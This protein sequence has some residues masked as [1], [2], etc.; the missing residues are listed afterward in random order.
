MVLEGKKAAIKDVLEGYRACGN[1]LLEVTVY[2][3]KKGSLKI[4]LW[5][6]RLVDTK[7]LN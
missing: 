1:G 2:A 4:G 3:Y 7:S 6:R 5:I